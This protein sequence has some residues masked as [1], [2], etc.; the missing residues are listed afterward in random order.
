MQELVNQQV[1]IYVPVQF[2][3]ITAASRNV[4]GLWV[5]GTGTPHLEAAT[6][7]Q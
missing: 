7:K 3:T 4:S 2:A 5:D 1:P 6:V